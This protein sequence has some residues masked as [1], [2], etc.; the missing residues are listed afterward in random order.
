MTNETGSSRVFTQGVRCDVQR[1]YAL[2]ADPARLPDWA[3][4]LAKGRVV[5]DSQGWVADTPAGHARLRFAPANALGVLD[6][7]VVPEG[8]DEVYVPFRVIATGPGRCELQITLLRLP[9]MDDT[10]FEGDGKTI[11]KDLASL[12]RLLEAGG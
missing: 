4:G 3:S 9:G 11:A 2:A 6:H 1:A 7:W 8:G 5:R 10:T 12:A